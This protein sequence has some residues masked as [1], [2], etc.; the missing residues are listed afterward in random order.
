M[1]SVKITREGDGGNSETP[2]HSLFP[3]S[4]NNSFSGEH[5]SDR[6]PHHHRREQPDRGASEDRQQERP[7]QCQQGHH[8]R[9][10]HW[11]QQR[12]RGRELLLTD[13]YAFLN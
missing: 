13:P 2:A 1:Q 12:L 11:K 3:I 6:R 5:R 8:G 10:D 4:L 7:G 9:H